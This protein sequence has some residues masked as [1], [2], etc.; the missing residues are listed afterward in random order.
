MKKKTELTPEQQDAFILSKLQ[1]NF[2]VATSEY[3]KVFRRMRKLDAVDNGDLW[4]SLHAKFPTYQILPDTNHISYIKNNI[5]ASIYT[6]GRCANILPTSDQDKDLVAQLNMMLSYIWGKCKVPMYQLRAGERAALLNLGVTQ[7]GWDNS[8]IESTDP[9]N[10]GH[11]RLKN[12]DPMHYMRDPYS[13]SLDTAAYVITWDSYH[14]NY[15]LSNVEYKTAFKTFLEKEQAANAS[16]GRNTPHISDRVS[17]ETSKRKDYYTVYVHF[18][19]TPEGKINEIHTIDNSFILYKRED[20]KPSMFP[21]AELYCNLPNKNLVGTSEPAKIFANSMAYNLMNSIILTSDYKNQRP[22]KFVNGSAG[23]NVASFTRHGNDADRTFIVQGDASQAVHYHQF[24]TPSQTVIQSMSILANDIKGVTGV[25]DRYT[26]RDTGS[27]ITTGGVENM[28]AQVTMIDATKIQLYEDYSLRLTQLILSNYMEF[29]TSRAYYLKDEVANKYTA[30]D[31]D[32]PSLDADKLFQYELSVSSYLPK[33]KATIQSMA[34]HLMEV[35]MQYGAQGNTEVDLITPQE[36]L[37][38]QDFPLAEYMSERMGL[39]R[40]LNWQ[41]A[42]SQIIEQYTTLVENGV[43]PTQAVEMTADT[44]A[45]QQDPANTSGAQ[46]AVENQN[47]L[48]P[49]LMQQYRTPQQEYYSEEE[50]TGDTY[51]EPEM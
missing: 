17:S 24:P 26:G 51:Y 1:D 37:Q 22:P 5:L 49:E 40:S 23:L 4:K 16:D 11:V 35:Q 43:N 21:F 18:I 45:A 15:L 46:T 48:N 39:Q 32:F 3:S 12:I 30:V 25:D 27:I 31:V 42:T 36:W 2:T 14:K 9:L 34:N 44:L 33:N 13:D 28:L 10:K 38:F 6:V 7:V 41:K 50:S 29:S 8:I 20:I 47:L 19:R